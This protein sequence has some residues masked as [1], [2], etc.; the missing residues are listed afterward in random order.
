[1]LDWPFV[2][3]YKKYQERR[4]LQNATR[5][6]K[7][8]APKF[9][10]VVIVVFFFFFSFFFFKVEA[11]VY[12]AKTDAVWFMLSSSHVKFSCQIDS[13]ITV[14]GK[15]LSI[16]SEGPFI[17]CMVVVVLGVIGLGV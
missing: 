9:E 10:L 1:M 13:A 16:L 11:A 8:E 6:I 17:F 14:S 2:V 12:V 15:G 4:T 5:K 3:S 7:L